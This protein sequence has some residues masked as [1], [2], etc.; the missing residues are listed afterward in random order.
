MPVIDLDKGI[1]NHLLGYV[2]Q[3]AERLRAR[4]EASW[5]RIGLAAAAMQQGGY[6]PRDVLLAQAELY[7]TAE[8]VGLDP[9]PAVE[10]IGGVPSNFETY[11]VVRSR[12]DRV[13]P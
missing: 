3:A 4:G 6:D 11:A 9:R 2:R 5:L 12:R 10:A 7:V 1:L 8:E 13:R